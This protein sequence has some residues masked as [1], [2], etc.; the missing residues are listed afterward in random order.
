MRISPWVTISTISHSL[1][2][3]VLISVLKVHITDTMGYNCTFKAAVQYP[4]YDYLGN[5]HPSIVD[6]VDT[7]ALNS[8]FVIG[9]ACVA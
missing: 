3:Y 5:L 8:I 9:G 1:C 7:T 2:Q 6:I 4:I